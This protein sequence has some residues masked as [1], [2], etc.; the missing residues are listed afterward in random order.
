MALVEGV[1][2]RQ[3]GRLK[4]GRTESRMTPYSEDIDKGEAQ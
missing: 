3:K 4:K 2:S 1:G